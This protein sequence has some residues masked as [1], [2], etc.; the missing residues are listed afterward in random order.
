MVERRYLEDI[1][2]GLE[3]ESELRQVTQADIEAFS[4]LTGDHDPLHTDAGAVG[5][6]S[7]YDAPIAHGLLVTSIS[8]GQ[9]TA[10]DDWDLGVYLEESRRFLAPVHA[11]DAIRT[12]ST[13][14]DVRRSRSN[15]ARGIV[16]LA[17][18][19]L[20]GRDELVQQGV[21]VVLVGARSR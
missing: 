9:P 15:P 10:A 6:G 7:P 8:S 13:V 1:D 17:V 20:N 12:V 18:R 11:G 16:T 3:L 14:T 21:D 4:R 2:V 5:P 19:V